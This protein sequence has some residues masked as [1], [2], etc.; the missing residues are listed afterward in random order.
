MCY[1]YSHIE[2]ICNSLLLVL[3]EE[4]LFMLWRLNLDNLEGNKCR[5]ELFD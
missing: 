2:K 1:L 5:Y 4:R 3:S